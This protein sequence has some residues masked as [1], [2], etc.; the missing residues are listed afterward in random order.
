MRKLAFFVA[1]LQ[2]LVLTATAAETAP[3]ASGMAVWLALSIVVLTPTASP[4][5]PGGEA[6]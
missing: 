4:W 1:V 2:F 3:E 6:S 5:R